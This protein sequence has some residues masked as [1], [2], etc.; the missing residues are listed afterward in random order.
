M[1]TVNGT[2]TSHTD[3]YAKL[4]DF[5]QNNAAL[6]ANGQKWTIAWTHPAGVQ[7]GVILRGPGLASQESISIGLALHADAVAD[8]YWIEVYG[9]AGVTASALTMLDHVNVNPTVVRMYLDA[10]AT[11]YWFV[12][13]GRRFVVVAKISTVFESLY[14]GLFLPYATP[15]AYPYPL[16]IGGTVGPK[17]PVGV[18]D[19]WRTVDQAHSAWPFAFVRE[20]LGTPVRTSC[21]VLSPAGEW[22]TVSGTEYNGAGNFDADVAIHP[23]KSAKLLPYLGV[24]QKPSQ[25]YGE[26]QVESHAALAPAAD[27][28][29]AL[30]HMHLVRIS[31]QEAIYGVFDGC[32]R[33]VGFG[34]AAEN[35]VTV[36]GTQ[37]LTVQ[38]TYRTAGGD[39]FAL[40]L[41]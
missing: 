19:S 35:I 3:L 11:R 13:N 7:A 10:G 38:N 29:L 24:D 12:A 2:A 23:N 20:D 36:D 31:A 25:V 17:L 41:E 26:G 30:T 39:Y 4:L 32:M 33:V 40:K 37:W 34:N 27:G 28:T 14:A 1:A 15:L 8:Q 21:Q 22:L 9:M 18:I 6:N 5:L 16:M